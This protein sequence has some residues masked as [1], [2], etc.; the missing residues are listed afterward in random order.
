MCKRN[1]DSYCNRAGY[2]FVMRVS[3]DRRSSCVL[4]D[5]LNVIR[6]KRSDRRDTHRGA[7]AE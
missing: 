7:I 1:C 5:G 3:Y 2:G 6:E 4:N